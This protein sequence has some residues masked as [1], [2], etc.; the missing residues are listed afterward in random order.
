[1]IKYYTQTS[2]R[3]WFCTS[4]IGVII[5]SYIDEF[6]CEKAKCN[7]I[8]SSKVKLLNLYCKSFF[9]I[10]LKVKHL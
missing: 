9:L 10:V 8:K 2:R 5:K 1:M 6:C 7:M 3:L 4:A